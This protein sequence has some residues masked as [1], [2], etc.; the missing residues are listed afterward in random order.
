MQ[1]KKKKIAHPRWGSN[2]QSFDAELEVKRVAIT[3]LGLLV[4]EDE[5]IVFLKKTL[6][7]HLPFPL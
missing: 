1:D 6:V 7:K 3:P 5:R 2:P 4:G